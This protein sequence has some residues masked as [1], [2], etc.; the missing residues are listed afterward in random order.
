M[1]LMLLENEANVEATSN[2]MRTPLHF[3]CACGHKEICRILM[4]KGR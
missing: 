1:T 4:D 3:A 2:D